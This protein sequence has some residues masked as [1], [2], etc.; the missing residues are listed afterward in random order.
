MK[1]HGLGSQGTFPIA[2]ALIVSY[3]LRSLEELILF[4]DS[5]GKF[6]FD[7]DFFIISEKHFHREIGFD[8]QLH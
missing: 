8:R 6:V 7:L 1:H 2:K 3:I 5:V 4:Q